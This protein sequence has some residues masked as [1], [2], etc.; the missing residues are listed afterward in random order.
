[1]RNFARAYAAISLGLLR[2][3]ATQDAATTELLR[4]VAFGPQ[5]P[6][7]NVQPACLLA[8][9]L[10]RDAASIPSLL[11]VA[12][13]RDEVCDARA[14]EA[15]GR[16]GQPA[17]EVLDVLIK[18][19]D[20]G[21]HLGHNARR[22]APGALARIAAN[23]LP[24]TQRK[25]VASLTAALVD[26]DV[27]VRGRAA[28]ALGR[29][30]GDPDTA[31][32][33]RGD[34]LA[35][36]RR[37]LD[38]SMPDNVRSYAAVALGLALHAEPCGV[39]AKTGDGI[40]ARLHAALTAPADANI[41]AACVLANGLAPESGA[42]PP[43]D[44]VTGVTNAA[45]P[46]RLVASFDD[47]DR[48]NLEMRAV[49]Q[50]LGRSGDAATVDALRGIAQDAMHSRPDFTRSCAVLAIGR[51]CGDFGPLDRALEGLEFRAYVPALAELLSGY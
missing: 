11:H 44:V 38:S 13:S 37:A 40:R 36:L 43:L 23:A 35:A 2:G 18:A 5:D 10:R 25:I 21:S 4:G 34:A 20:R 3:D 47:M 8:L 50:A 39:A 48:G 19:L 7:P 17:P 41:R 30:A 42:V 29:I 51:I 1:M 24:E 9:G 26:D 14:V 31:E 45:D 28:T 16:I 46:A 49:V 22:A 12:A 27:T 6:D 15:L 33:A 32:A